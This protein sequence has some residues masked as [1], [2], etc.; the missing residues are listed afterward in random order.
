MFIKTT[1]GGKD[2]NQL[3]VSIPRETDSLGYILFAGDIDGDNIPDFVIDTA[4]HENAET[5]T[6]YLS[7]EAENG[8]LLKVVGLH[9]I[10]GC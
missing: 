3:L 4:F 5:T 1:I 8:D 9:S 7:G 2:Y 6:L 10:T